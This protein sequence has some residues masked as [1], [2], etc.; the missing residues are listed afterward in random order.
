M[1]NE[2]ILSILKT[3]SSYSYLVEE[4]NIYDYNIRKKLEKIMDR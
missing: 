1:S 2:A 3:N 4:G